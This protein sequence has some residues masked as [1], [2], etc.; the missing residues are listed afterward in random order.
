MSITDNSG[1]VVLDMGDVTEICQAGSG[2]GYREAENRDSGGKIIVITPIAERR[3]YP[4]E[5]KF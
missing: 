4:K 5:N 3:S 1:D 2:G